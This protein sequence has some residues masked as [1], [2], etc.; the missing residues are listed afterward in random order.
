M[1]SIVKDLSRIT[2]KNIIFLSVCLATGLYS[3]HVFVP[4][5]P[6][7]IVASEIIGADIGLLFLIGII[8]GPMVSMAGYIWIKFLFKKEFETK[9]ERDQI[10]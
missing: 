2:K 10:L 7:P 3:A 5:T 4:P 8:V 9:S 6:G 1:S